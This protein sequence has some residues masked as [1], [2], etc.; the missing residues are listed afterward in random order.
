VA[1]GFFSPV[2][3]TA[4]GSSIVATSS[5]GL[6]SVSARDGKRIALLRAETASADVSPDGKYAIVSVV[7]QTADAWMIEGF[8]PQARRPN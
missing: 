6:W 1:E 5:G 7:D 4:D 3:W 2:G 8:D